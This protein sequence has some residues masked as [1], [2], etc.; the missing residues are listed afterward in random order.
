MAHV[1]RADFHGDAN[2]GLFGIVT[3]KYAVFAPNERFNKEILNVPFV[4]TYISRTNLV[5]LFLA[6][7]SNGLLVSSIIDEKEFL[8]LKEQMKKIAPDVTVELIEAKDN[9]IGNLI[10]CNDHGAIVSQDLR[11]HLAQIARVLKVPVVEGS[12]MENDLVGTF[13]V[14]TNKGFLLTMNAEESEYEFFKKH[15]KVN[16]DIGSSNFGGIFVKSGVLANSNGFLAGKLSTGP[17]IGRIDEAL[18]FI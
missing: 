1:D 7:N 4:H 10:V 16:G 18:G 14:A 8:H 12:V 11:H 3:D 9:A 17:E 15:L 2:I 5:G 6:G 13:C